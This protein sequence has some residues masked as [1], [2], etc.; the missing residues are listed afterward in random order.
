[1]TILL[2]MGSKGLQN[3]EIQDLVWLI[4]PFRETLLTPYPCQ[5]QMWQHEAAYGV[6]VG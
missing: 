5:P 1:M 3:I 2:S 6:S 4:M